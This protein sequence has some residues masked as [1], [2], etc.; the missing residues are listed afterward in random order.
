MSRLPA[1]PEVPA[2][3]HRLG[4]A[5]F[6]LAALT[7]SVLGVATAQL[8]HAGLID[9]FEAVFSADDVAALK[10]SPAPLPDGRRAM[11]RRDRGRC[12]S[13]PP[14]RG[15]S[16]V[17]GLTDG[18]GPDSVIDAVGMEAHKS[19]GATASRQVDG[20][21]LAAVAAPLMNAPGATGWRR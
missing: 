21:L 1:H 20:R 8:T 11:R 10:P 12:A 18:R 6:R 19:P 2:A 15:R 7:N 9:E 14:T 4:A 5:G 17:R 16:R 13:S 3:L